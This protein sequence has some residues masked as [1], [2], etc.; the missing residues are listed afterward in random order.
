M[1]E[2]RQMETD[3]LISDEM[4]QS[5]IINNKLENILGGFYVSNEWLNGIF[6]HMENKKIIKEFIEKEKSR[7]IIDNVISWRK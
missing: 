6:E 2:L 3:I 4:K 1:I 7:R 5:C